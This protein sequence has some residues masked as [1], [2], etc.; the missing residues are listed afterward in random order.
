MLRVKN[1]WDPARTSVPNR[2]VCVTGVLQVCLCC[3]CASGVFVLQVCSRCVCVTGVLQ[4]CLCCR[5]APGVFVLQVCFRCVCVTGV[6]VVQ[7]CLCYSGA[8]G[9]LNKGNSGRRT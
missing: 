1:S 6:Y 2:C 9:F 8:P 3:R 5:C 4:V 7:V